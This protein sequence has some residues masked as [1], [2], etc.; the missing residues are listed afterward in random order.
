MKNKLIILR[1]FTVNLKKHL[2]LIK[3][4]DFKI[5][6]LIFSEALPNH[7]VYSYAIENRAITKSYILFLVE[8][9]KN[10]INYFPIFFENI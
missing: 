6:P 10:K 4:E 5:T 8:D 9:T 3:N 2:C 1:E 7:P